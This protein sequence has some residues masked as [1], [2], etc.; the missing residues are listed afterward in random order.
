MWGKCLFVCFMD[1]LSL[2]FY[3]RR[4]DGIISLWESGTQSSGVLCFSCS[5]AMEWDSESVKSEDV[6][7]QPGNPEAEVKTQPSTP[8]SQAGVRLHEF[9][10]KTVRMPFLWEK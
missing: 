7:K 3:R 1:I 5:A 6:F 10:S 8:Q 9:V 4:F 2:Y